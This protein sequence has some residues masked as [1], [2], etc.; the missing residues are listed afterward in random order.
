MKVSGIQA[1]VVILHY[2][3]PDMTRRLYDQLH[4][5]D[6]GAAIPIFVL[7]NAAPEPYPQAWRRL[8]ENVYW[9][10]ALAYAARTVRE[11][12]CTHLWFLNNDIT[13]VSR[14]PY[15][16]RTFGR[17]ARLD[18]TLGQ[19][20]LYSPAFSKSPYHPQMVVRPGGQY[21]QVRVMDGV[22]P[23]IDLACLEKI[24]GVD[25][26]DNPFGYGVDI[27][28]SSQIEAAGWKLVVDHQVVVNHRHH[29]TARAV[30]GFLEM[31]AKAEAGY[32]QKRL[33][34]DYLECI[35]RWKLQNRESDSL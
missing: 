25:F 18:A 12:G 30:P 27:L 21:R 33:G 22:A 11:I 2:G 9:A 28:L 15:L 6:P 29:T 20:G 10:G 5:S 13:F 31:A 3:N 14:P 1:A 17:L 23:L 8:E 16:A 4:R 7:D 19:V 35:A 34:P 26:G 24:G 32:L